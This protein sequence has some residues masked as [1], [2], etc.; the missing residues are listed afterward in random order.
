MFRVRFGITKSD[1]GEWSILDLDPF[2]PL[3]PVGLRIQRGSASPRRSSTASSA[4]TA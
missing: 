3:L 4:T 2:R 1:I